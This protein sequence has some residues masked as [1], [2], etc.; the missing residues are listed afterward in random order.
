MLKY[1]VRLLKKRKKARQMLVRNKT[2][3]EQK[4]VKISIRCR[5][6][7]YRKERITENKVKNKVTAK[8]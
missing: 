7:L 1:T 6:R 3:R 4:A 5:Y 8:L 2:G